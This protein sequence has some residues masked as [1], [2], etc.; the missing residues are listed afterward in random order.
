VRAPAA[1]NGNGGPPAFAGTGFGTKRERAVGE[2][3]RV[4]AVASQ[5][6]LLRDGLPALY[7]EGD[8]GM[9]FVGALETVLNPVVAMLDALPAHF[10]PDL[11]PADVLAL[12]AA[13]VGLELD[14]SQSVEEQRA[15]VRRGA[16]LSRTRGTLHGLRLA[17]EL[18][19]P[20]LPLRVEDTGGVL[21]GAAAAADGDAGRRAEFV[22]WCD[23]PIAEDVQA[24]LARRIEHLRPVHAT[25]RLRVR[26]ARPEAPS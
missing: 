7:R 1:T 15:M 24:A 4:P 23:A 6:A 8:F 13:W 12:L 10:D 21:R 22:V 2:A 16:E 14:E 26:A 11:A 25:Y 18:A 3:R 20:E 19:F 5:R 17:L 9:R